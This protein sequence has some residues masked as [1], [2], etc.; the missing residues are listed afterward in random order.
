MLFG[1]IQTQTTNTQTQTTLSLCVA[2]C[3]MLSCYGLCSCLLVAVSFPNILL[4]NI[5]CRKY[6]PE[7]KRLPLKYLFEPWRAPFKVQKAA[8]CIVGDDYPEPVA[9]HTE[10][11]KICVQRLKDLCISLDISGI[12]SIIVYIYGVCML[13]LTPFLFKFLHSQ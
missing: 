5:P 6:V 1:N 3:H 12:S 10:Q 8:R 13:I 9:S 7:L 11:R 4:V 2:V